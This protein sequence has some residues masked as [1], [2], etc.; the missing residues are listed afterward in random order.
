MSRDS[1]NYCYNYNEKL[2]TKQREGGTTIKHTIG[3]VQ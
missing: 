2:N 1:D 3:F